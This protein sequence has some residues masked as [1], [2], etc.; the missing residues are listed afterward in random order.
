MLEIRDMVETTQLEEDS[1]AALP[2]S[3]VEL[4]FNS[5]WGNIKKTP[6]RLLHYLPSKLGGFTIASGGFTIAKEVRRIKQFSK[7][8]SDH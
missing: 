5:N 6:Y 8:V 3:I 1:F 4:K 2:A 7:P